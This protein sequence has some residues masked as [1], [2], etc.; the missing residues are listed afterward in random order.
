MP[1]RPGSFRSTKPAPARRQL[2]PL[3]CCGQQ[4]A[5]ARERARARAAL[6]SI[7]C[8][9]PQPDPSAPGALASGVEIEIPGSYAPAQ[10]IRALHYQQLPEHLRLLEHRRE[11]DGAPQPESSRSRESSKLGDQEALVVKLT[12]SGRLP[13]PRS[14]VPH[15]KRKP[16]RG[17]RWQASS[18]AMPAT[19]IGGLPFDVEKAR[20]RFLASDA[21]EQ[22]RVRRR[23][24]DG[25]RNPAEVFTSDA[26]G[27]RLFARWGQ[28][29]ESRRL[30][31][32]GR[33]TPARTYIWSDFDRTGRLQL[34]RPDFDL[35][36]APAV[37]VLARLSSRELQGGET[38]GGQVMDS[39][40]ESNPQSSTWP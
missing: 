21:P 3:A 23:E 4:D 38:L 24:G 37:A 36:I 10:S 19:E 26:A 11:S 14:A 40:L 12:R 30:S 29:D 6:I 32:G 16:N 35:S 17:P 31:V 18:V 5:P 25:G 33:L 34:E 13:L 8:G 7:L 1:R 20:R 22:R 9:L 39:L 15:L 27:A 28:P 2:V